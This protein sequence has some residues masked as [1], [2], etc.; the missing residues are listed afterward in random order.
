[1]C[2]GRYHHFAYAYDYHWFAITILLPWVGRTDSDLGAPLGGRT[3]SDLGAPL[4]VPYI[5][6]QM[7][8]MPTVTREGELEYGREVQLPLGYPYLSV[9]TP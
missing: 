6:A 3:D 1:M 8:E 4:P 7:I 2:L 9:P 5:D